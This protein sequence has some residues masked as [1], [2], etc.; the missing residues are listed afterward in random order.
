MEMEIKAEPW[1]LYLILHSNIWPSPSSFLSRSCDRALVLPNLPIFQF[2]YM[3]SSPMETRGNELKIE[4]LFHPYQG[5]LKGEVSL[6][7]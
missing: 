6:Y 1:L 4:L 7:S 3:T 5:I 2:L